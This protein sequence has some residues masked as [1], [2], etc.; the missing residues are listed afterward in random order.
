MKKKILVILP[1]PLAV[2]DLM[3]M[4][5]LFI[6]LKI[7]NPGVMLDVLAA[8]KT[9]ELITRMPEIRRILHSPFAHR[10]L[11][12]LLRYQFGKSLRVENYDQVILFSTSFKAGLMPWF[13]RIPLRTGF[14][15]KWGLS[16]LNDAQ[17]LP[18]PRLPR[19]IQRLLALG[20]KPG[21]MIDEEMCWPKI[22]ANQTSLLQT[23]AKFQLLNDAAPIL[24]L[25]PGSTGGAS[26]RW[27]ENYFSQLAEYFLF[28]GWKVWCVGGPAER[29]IVA[30]INA[31]LEKPTVDL[32][33]TSL[34]EALDLMSLAT[35]VVA[36]DSGLMHIAAALGVSVVALY[37]S[38]SPAFTPPLTRNSR[39]LY[40]SLPCQPCYQRECPL[41]HLNCLKQIA[42]S[43]VIDAIQSLSQ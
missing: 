14:R 8:S 43:E 17:L 6:L 20:L 2:G 29:E 40:K 15:R 9:P 41:E 37:G 35:A 30:R 21:E 5:S 38:G 39:V 22:S 34:T 16:L 12:V 7:K 42:V 10:K 26:K 4:Q 31:N 18:R 11:N 13:A 33:H 3:M 1:S 24:V 25:C 19:M 28:K 27:P 23:L 32:S 36:N